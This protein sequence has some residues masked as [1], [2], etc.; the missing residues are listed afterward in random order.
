MH[1]P[2]L[3]F[4]QHLFL[5]QGSEPLPEDVVPFDAASEVPLEEQRTDAM[6]RIQD[7]LLAGRA[8]EALSLL[9]SAR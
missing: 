9:H 3:G 7:S 8:P 5:H 4:M 1:L 6:V 2:S